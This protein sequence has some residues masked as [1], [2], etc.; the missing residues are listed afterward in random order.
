MWPI[1]HQVHAELLPCLEVGAGEPPG[2]PAQT[3]VNLLLLLLLTVL[4]EQASSCVCVKR[5]ATCGSN[6]CSEQE[7]PV[8]VRCNKISTVHLV[9]RMWTS[10]QFACQLRSPVVAGS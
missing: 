7:V 5:Q 6:A 3:S 2:G 9:D 1:F 4:S 8:I 10:C